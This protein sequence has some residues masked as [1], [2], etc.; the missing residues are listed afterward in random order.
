MEFGY[1]TYSHN[2]KKKEPLKH[3]MCLYVMDISEDNI[4]FDYGAYC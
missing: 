3:I 4:Q 1:S 2:C